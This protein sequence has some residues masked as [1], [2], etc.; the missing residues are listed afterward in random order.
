DATVSMS[1]DYNGNAT[2]LSKQVDE[3]S[4]TISVL[5]PTL[6][7][8]HRT[9]RDQ[10]HRNQALEK[11]VG[12]L[13]SKL[14]VSDEQLSWH[15]KRVS[16][17]ETELDRLTTDNASLG[18]RLDRLEDDVAKRQER[19]GRLDSELAV[20]RRRLAERETSSRLTETRLAKRE[21]E[22]LASRASVAQLTNDV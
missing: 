4:T 8:L 6:V 3:L 2:T 22:L 19:I 17:V 21:A 15:R 13:N 12:E 9:S 7:T 10:E 16:E 11:E 1:H 20:E 5:Y 14:R 18:E